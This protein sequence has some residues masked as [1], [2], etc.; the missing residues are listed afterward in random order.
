MRRYLPILFIL[1]IAAALRLIALD[2]VP[3]GLQHD[4][5]FHGHDAVTVLLGYHPLYFTSNAGNEPL[6]IYLMSATINLFGSTVFGIRIA[7]VICGVLTIVFSYLWIKRTFNSRTAL[8]ASALMAVNFWS[9]FMSRVGL[10]A[11]S[12]PMM[13]ALTAWLLFRNVDFGLRNSELGSEHSAVRNPQSAIV[14]GIA[15]GLTLYTY[16]AA[17][18]F[19]IV[20]LLFWLLTSV[21]SKKFQ[22]QT[23]FVLITAAIVIAPLAYIIATQPQADQRLQQLGGPVQ[24]ALHGNWQPVLTYSVQTLGLFTFAGDPIARYNLPGRPIFDPITGLLFYFGLL[25]ALKRWRDPRNLFVLLWLPIGLLPSMLSDSAPSFLRASVSL[26]VTFLFPALTLDWILS[27]HR[28]TETRRLY[29]VFG[30]LVSLWLV[31]AAVFTIRDYFFVWPNR[32][33]VREVYRSDL[34]DAARWIEQ[35]PIDQPIEIASTNP[36][37]LDPFLYDFELSGQHDIRW[38]DRAYALAFPAQRSILISPAYSPIDPTLR[39]RFLATPV[40]TSTSFE[41][42]ELNGASTRLAPTNMITIAKTDLVAL[43]APID[44][45]HSLEFLGYQA[46]ATAKPG[47]WVK[48]TLYWRVKKDVGAQQLPVSLF[49][50]LLND[51]GEF[52]AGRDLLAYPTASWRDGDMWIQQNDVQVPSTQIAGILQLELGAY[53][54]ADNIRWRIYDPA[55]NDVGDRLLLSEVTVTP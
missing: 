46:D 22:K 21:F 39:D 13:V 24:D 28:G 11:T 10:R 8:I 5:V 35:Q 40:F 44:L 4:E 14:A 54:Q 2:Q 18:V 45:N 33:D 48:L 51:R 27:N 31:V 32:S 3:P 1:L 38:I 36:R 53:S 6:F 47:E 50:H 43:T 12:L 19:P 41:V 9:L 7:A 30:V 25:L 20:F 49:V 29:K 17:R 26:P 15:L 23:L 55:G 16:P 37:D 42:Y 52:V 34:A